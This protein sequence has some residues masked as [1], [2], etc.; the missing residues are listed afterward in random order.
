MCGHSVVRWFR[1]QNYTLCI[2]TISL[3]RY[4]FDWI[5]SH[6]ERAGIVVLYFSQSSTHCIHKVGVF[7]VTVCVLFVVVISFIVQWNSWRETVFDKCIKS[8]SRFSTREVC[9]FRCQ[10]FGISGTTSRGI[11]VII[12]VHLICHYIYMHFNYYGYDFI[13]ILLHWTLS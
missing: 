2:Q 1:F 4:P 7:H 10:S 11:R 13:Y 3:L 12:V 6:I 9:I 5:F 8:L